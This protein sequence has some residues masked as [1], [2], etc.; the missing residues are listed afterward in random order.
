MA[1]YIHGL[2]FA[3][4]ILEGVVRVFSLQGDVFKQV[5]TEVYIGYSPGATGTYV[6]PTQPT[7]RT[8]IRINRDGYRGPDFNRNALIR[9]AFVGDSF[10]AAMEVP[11]E[12][13]FVRRVEADLSVHH[14]SVACFN[15][16]LDGSGTGLQ[17]LHFSRRVVPL[18]PRLVVL[19]ITVG[20]DFVDNSQE[21]SW[22]KYY[23]SW[24]FDGKQ[25]SLQAPKVGA[26]P[27]MNLARR[28]RAAGWLY[29]RYRTLA[30]RTPKVP[31]TEKELYLRAARP[32]WR[33]AYQLTLELISRF[34]EEAHEN[35]IVPVVLLIPTSCQVI[36]APS[37]DAR[38]D[39]L[40]PQKRIKQKLGDRARLIDL[41]PLFQAESQRL[42]DPSWY[43]F[44]RDGHLN[45]EGHAFVSSVLSRSLLELLDQ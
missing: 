22:K 19:Q 27:I 11:Y 4:L 39:L 21:L 32:E 34:V 7:I 6:S 28:S 42:G 5:D 36:N 33:R 30:R 3:L 43:R 35:G 1:A 26:P 20:N 38:F 15:F 8:P 37:A 45:E 17:L 16:G 44:D 40:L 9:V 23:P 13:C 41:L 18:D 31:C 29:R 25:L 10:T 12:K 24:S 2:F 14:P